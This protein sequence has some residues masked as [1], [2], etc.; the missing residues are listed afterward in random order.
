MIDTPNAGLPVTGLNRENYLAGYLVRLANAM[1]RGGSRTYLKLFGVGV[2][3]WRILSMLALEPGLMAQ[4]LANGLEMDKAPVSRSVRTLEELEMITVIPHPQKSRIRLLTLTSK[5][6]E[7][8]NRILSLALEREAR[9]L[10]GLK[11]SEV[12][13][14]FAI[15][16]KLTANLEDLSQYEDAL[17]AGTIQM[18]P[19]IDPDAKAS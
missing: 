8:H 12:A 16:R 4:Q 17:L 9:V 7:L 10:K 1:S 3:E 11:P 19:P 13:C 2:V 6:A 15:L 14:L 5:G 18:P